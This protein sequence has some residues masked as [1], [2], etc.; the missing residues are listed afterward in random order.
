M[1]AFAAFLVT[2]LSILLGL[3]ACASFSS[4]DRFG[5][6]MEMG[7]AILLSMLAIYSWCL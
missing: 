5:A 1:I 6:A 2:A 7:G 3:S 4:G